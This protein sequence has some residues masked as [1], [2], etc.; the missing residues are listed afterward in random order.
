VSEYRPAEGSIPDIHPREPVPASIE[1]QVA[2]SSESPPTVSSRGKKALRTAV[3]LI[4]IILAAGGY[5]LISHANKSG[6][7]SQ[8]QGRVTLS[9]SDLRNLVVTKHL[10]VYWAGP[11][12]GAKYTLTANT[13]GVAYV[14]YLPGGVGL[15]DTKTLFRV[16]GTYAQKS[17]FRVAQNTGAAPGNVGFI[18]ADGNGVFYSSSRPSNVYIGIKGKD[19]QIEVFDPV[20]D[21]ALGLVLVRNQI[22]QIV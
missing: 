8:L 14:K 6:D 16:I 13:P 3:F 17:A 21:Q 11:M 7:I 2:M 1:T 22:R 15:N 12:A 4:I 5:Y 9:D 18:N 20:V 19:I 10:T